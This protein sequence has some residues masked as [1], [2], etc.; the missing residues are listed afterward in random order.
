VAD[1]FGKDTNRV[2]VLGKD[3]ARCE[4][5]GTKLSLAHAIWNMVRDRLSG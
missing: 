2:L 1:A 5:S 3:G 4:L